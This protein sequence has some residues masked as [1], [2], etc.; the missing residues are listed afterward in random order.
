[1]P[2]AL[3]GDSTAAEQLFNKAR[4]LRDAG[5]KKEA[6]QKFQAS[7]DLDP[8]IGALLNI[9]QCHEEEGRMATAY[10]DYQRAIE[11]NRATPNEQRKK[12]YADFIHDRMK[13]V[14][15]RVPRLVIIVDGRHADLKVTRNG[16]DVPP[17]ALGEPL[18]VDPGEVVVVA[19]AGNL[20]GEQRIV[21]KESEQKT[22]RLELKP[23][24][25]SGLAATRPRV[26]PWV[27]GGVGMVVGAAGIAFAVDYGITFSKL[28]EAC[29]GDLEACRP[30]D[31]S[32]DVAAANARKNRDIA[33]GIALG[34][35][36]AIGV[37][38]GIGG[39]VTAPSRSQGGWLVTP[40]LARD[41]GGLFAVGRF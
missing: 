41:E 4:K 3:A 15:P 21:I 37:G 29:K 19:A 39:L 27:V 24:T 22:M 36:G 34:A 17:G 8:S 1:M 33:L 5:Q 9:A 2:S 25:A 30:D 14:V 35:A 20:S 6:C 11:L 18:P 40:W 23:G 38:L 16:Q 32:Y 10:S 12:E 26:W 28:K 7:M 31:P 13:A